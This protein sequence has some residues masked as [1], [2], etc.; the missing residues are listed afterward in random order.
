M[1]CVSSSDSGV[2]GGGLPSDRKLGSDDVVKQRRR[3]S[4]TPGLVGD[5]E[6]QRLKLQVPE[7]KEEPAKPVRRLSLG[8]VVDDSLVQ[9][10]EKIDLKHTAEAQTQSITNE[11]VAVT[12]K[13]FVPYNLSKANQ[14]SYIMKTEICGNSQW[15]MFGVCDGHGEFGHRELFIR[16]L[17]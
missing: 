10:E 13:G 9:A 2:D 1:G 16:V 14:D 12:K 3:L 7:T 5:V 6:G 11:F 17:C 4:V 15:S 8:P